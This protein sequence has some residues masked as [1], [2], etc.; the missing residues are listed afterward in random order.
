ME[1]LTTC[2]TLSTSKLRM[3]G[4]ELRNISKDYSVYPSQHNTF[5]IHAEDKC[6]KHRNLAKDWTSLPTALLWWKATSSVTTVITTE[7]GRR[8]PVCY[9]NQ[10]GAISPPEA[11]EQHV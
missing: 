6:I 4:N 8:I 2:P 11:S 5:P 3:L 7:R 9:E 10:G 1:S